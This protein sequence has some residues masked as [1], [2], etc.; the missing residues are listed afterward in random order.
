MRTEPTS[1]QTLH[2]L[3]PILDEAGNVET[4]FSGF[5]TIQEQFSGLYRSAYCSSMMAAPTAARR[6]RSRSRDGKA[7]LWK[8]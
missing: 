3:I 4:L 7:S 1:R 2:L 8:S 6:S 5:R